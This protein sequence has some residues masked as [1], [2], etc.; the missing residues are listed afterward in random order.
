V[1]VNKKERV[2]KIKLDQSEQDGLA[3]D[4]REAKFVSAA[5]SLSVWRGKIQSE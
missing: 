1:P 2:E 3:A 5:F 4:A